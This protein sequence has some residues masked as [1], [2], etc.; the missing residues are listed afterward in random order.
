MSSGLKIT[1]A[2]AAA[3]AA[4][5]LLVV[6]GSGGTDHGTGPEAGTPM[7]PF[8]APLAASTLVGDANISPAACEVSAREAVTS[9]GVVRSGPAA[10]GFVTTDDGECKALAGD[11][12]QAARLVPGLTPVAVGIRG[13]RKP[14]AKLAAS[15]PGATVLWDRDGA[16]TNRYGVAVCPM[17]VVVRKGGI[18][19][20]SL[21]G[22]G[23]DGPQKLAVD[24]RR[25]LAGD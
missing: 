22:S 17:V 8:A 7:P 13:E 11:L 9:C 16:L 10:I 3:I 14:L 24:I 23:D 20:G 6:L 21:I 4:V 18:V 12:A 15:T 1:A 2:L 5:A 19:A 25:L